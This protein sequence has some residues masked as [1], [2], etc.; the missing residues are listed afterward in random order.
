[1]N[2]FQEQ[3]YNKRFD[4][5]LWKNLFGYIKS[6]RKEII[7]LGIVMVIVAGIDAIFPLL[8]K[9]A[10]DNF[11]IPK[12]TEG[13]GKFAL[14]F[15]VIVIFQAISVGLFI[16]L[17]G[18]IETGISYDI[19]KKGFKKLQELSFSY[20]DKKA[21][22][23]LMARMT[24]DVRRL[25]QTISWGVV[26]LV[27]G[28]SMMIIIMVIMVFLNLKLALITLTVVPFLVVISLYFQKKILKAFRQVRKIN[29]RITGAFNEGIM[30]ART[31]KTLVREEENLKEFEDKT[32]RMESSSIRAA[33]FSSLYLPIVLTLGSIGTAFALWFGGSRVIYNTITYGTLVAFISYT[34]RFFEPIRQVARIFAELQS[35]QASAERILSMIET[36]PEIKDSREIIQRYGDKYNP[37]EENWPDIEGEIWFKNVDFYYNKNE[38]I[39]ENFNL[40][41]K[42]GETVALVG[43]TGS[44]KITIANLACRFY[45]P[46]EGEVLI[47]GIDYR[48]RSQLWLH[49]HLGYVLQDPH[50]FSGTI[51]ENIKYGKLE[52]NET[53]VIRAAQLVNAH[54]FIKNLSKGYDTELGESGDNLS[55]GQKQLISFARAVISDP[56]IFILDEATSSIDTEMEYLIQKAIE[57]ILKGRTNIIIAH[58]LSTIKNADRII[59]LQDGNIIESGS[60]RELLNQKGYYYRLYTTQ[61][62]QAN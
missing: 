43:E 59:V 35:A 11:V 25:G 14:L 39:L 61:F 62:M 50:L 16:A 34:I 47:D 10:V 19:R 57:K 42:A 1:M 60:H 38:K 37:I 26:D 44:G 30:G 12:S 3:E 45:E 32:T 56:K 4:W 13:I 49:S 28:F 5:E 46:R 17:S 18:K 21:V 51:K 8:S 2:E 41:I 31:T 23:W 6:Y 22:G 20:Y 27:W 7:L 52:A 58:R 53:E 9:Y 24:S 55:T 33:I 54:Q 36:E 48:K 15:G 40:K 29:S